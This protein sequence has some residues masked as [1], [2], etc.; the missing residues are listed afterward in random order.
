MDYRQREANSDM[1][2]RGNGFA[3]VYE[4]APVYKPSTGIEHRPHAAGIGPGTSEEDAVDA[5]P[6]WGHPTTAIVYLSLC[7]GENPLVDEVSDGTTTYR[8]RTPHRDTGWR[9]W[10]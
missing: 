5:D 10:W 2:R 6:C 9:V 7:L 4:H 1:T 8:I 3:Q